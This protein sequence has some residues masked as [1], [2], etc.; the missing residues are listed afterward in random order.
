[1]PKLN[2]TIDNIE[3]KSNKIISTSNT[4][5]GTWTDA[6][7]ISAKAA[8]NAAHPVGSILITSTAVNPTETLGGEWSLVDKAFKGTYMQVPT[9]AWTA[10]NATMHSTSNIL[11]IDHMLHLRLYLVT[12]TAI[13]NDNDIVLGKL[14]LSSCGILALST[15]LY[16]QPAISDNGN[17]TICYTV[18][19]DGTVSIVDVLNVKGDHSAVAGTDIIINI[20]LPVGYDRMDS[21]YCDK[22][23]WKRNA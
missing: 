8:L 5:P 18:E 12:T 2:T 13:T 9:A 14:D 11:L 21:G 23:F 1:M 15:A 10:T 3:L 6:Q 7:Y 17:C 22:F 4:S 16:R 19:S 20:V